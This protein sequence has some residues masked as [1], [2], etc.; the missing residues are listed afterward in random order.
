MD[1][2]HKPLTTQYYIHHRQNHLEIISFVHI[3]QTDRTAL[4]EGLFRETE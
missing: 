2:V 3:V 1:K 4:P